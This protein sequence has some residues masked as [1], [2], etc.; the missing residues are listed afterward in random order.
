M[1]VA[2]SYLAYR[3]YPVLESL[4]MRMKMRM[5]VAGIKDTHKGERLRE[6]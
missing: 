6:I 3:P 2:L 1:H 4:V 5:V